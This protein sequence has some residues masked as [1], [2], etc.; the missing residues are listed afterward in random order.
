MGLLPL[1]Y[2]ARLACDL[3]RQRLERSLVHSFFQ[4]F[5][6]FETWFFGC[7]DLQ[8]LA[9]LRVTA[10]ASWAVGH[11]ESTETNQYHGVA[12]LESASDGFDYCVQRTASSSF[13]DISRCSDS[14]NQFRLVHSKSPYIYLSMILSFLV[15]AKIS[16][17]WPTGT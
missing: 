2:Q 16:A 4:G 17:E 13:R 6:S 14:I 1:R 5:T 7:G 15:K 9:S 10:S 11:R 3:G 8:R 12:G